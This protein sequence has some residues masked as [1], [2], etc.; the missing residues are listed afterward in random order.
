MNG[1][2][3]VSTCELCFKFAKYRTRNIMINFITSKLI[4]MNISL[5]KHLLKILFVALFSIACSDDDR[6]VEVFS[7]VVTS[8]KIY[9]V[10]SDDC[11]ASCSHV[12]KV[13]AA[14]INGSANWDSFTYDITGFT[15]EPGFEYNIMVEKESFNDPQMS[16][17][18]WVEFTLLEVISKEE[19]ISEGLSAYFE[20]K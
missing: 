16:V 15:Y 19:K 3:F 4:T 6:D 18:T 1:L 13:L 20:P 9:G 11:G 2:F 7:M 17:T 8:E 14:K 5:D 12:A 10:I